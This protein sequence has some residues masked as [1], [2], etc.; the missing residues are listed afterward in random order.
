MGGTTNGFGFNGDITD[1]SMG[2]DAVTDGGFNT[3]YGFE[4]IENG[5]F[6]TT[7]GTDAV[8]DGGFESGYGFEAVTNGSFATDTD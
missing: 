3:G 4:T 8:V 5:D 1:G 2:P 7:L 6:A